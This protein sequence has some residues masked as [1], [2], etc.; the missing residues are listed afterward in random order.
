M[1]WSRTSLIAAASVAFATSAVAQPPV[2]ATRVSFADAV[3]QA[4]AR[5]PTVRAAAAAILRAAGQLRV[6]RAASL[7]QLSAAV[8]TTTLNTSVE[9]DGTTVTPQNSVTASITADMPI[10]AAAAW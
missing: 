10:L 2:P 1:S 7:V 5:N 9:F 8:T 4:I 3:Q 6:A